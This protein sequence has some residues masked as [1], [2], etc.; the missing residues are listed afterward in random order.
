MSKIR[1]VFRAILFCLVVYIT[2]PASGAEKSN[3]VNY[4]F[5]GVNY[6]FALPE[7]FCT[8]KG[9]DHKMADM[10]ASF[11]DRNMTHF[12]IVPC[13]EL[14]SEADFT[15]WGMLKTPRASI[16][17]RIPTRKALVQDFKKDIKRN[18]LMLLLDDSAKL[19]GKTFS[20]VFGADCKLGM[21]VEPVDAD[22]YAGYMAGMAS[23]SFADQKMLVACAFAMTVV[24]E[25]VFFYYKYAQYNGLSDIA[26]LLKQVKREIRSF[27]A[28]NPD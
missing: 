7:G 23:M 4:H 1:L 2:I 27:V 22:E 14:E 17:K 9:E 19:V 28:N 18:D 3:S 11:D 8:P 21:H 26:D 24:R 10:L 16:G 13:S 6:M 12:T 20:K 25:H 15:R 5:D